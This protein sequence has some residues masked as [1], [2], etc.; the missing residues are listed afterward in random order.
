MLRGEDPHGLLTGALADP[1]VRPVLT[2]RGD[3]GRAPRALV[4][5]RL[6]PAAGA[7]VP[8]L[9]ALVELL[10]E[11][12]CDEITIGSSLSREDRDRG[13]VSV[14]QRAHSS[15]LTGR[16]ARG[17]PYE[18]VDLRRETVPAPVPTTSVLSGHLVS[19]RWLAADLR[20]VVAGAATDLGEGFTGCLA[21]LAAAAA[22]VPGAAPCDVVADLLTHLPPHLGVVDAMATSHGPDGGRIPHEAETGV[23]LVGDPV[24]ADCVLAGLLGTDRSVSSHVRAALARTGEP[25]GAVAGDLTPLAGLRRPDPLVTAAARVV[26]ADPSLGRLL[27]AAVG[28][29]DPG[30][31]PTDPGAHPT[32]PVLATLRRVLTPLVEGANEPVGR[33][34]LLQ[35]LGVA[36]LVS[37]QLRGWRTVLDKDRV[38]RV[39]VPL[40]FAPADYAGEEY[41]GL[42]GVLEPLLRP[43]RD[44][45]VGAGGFRWCLV[46]GA[47]VFETART[48][49]A[50]FAEFVARVDVAEGISLMADYLGG[51]RVVVG[52]AP[53]GGS[54]QA[55]RNLYLPQPN[56]LA[57]W[58]GRPIDVCK[59][60]LVE[61]TATEHRLW[62]RTV[63]SP[64]G[65][66]TCDD[67][68][69]TVADAGPGRTRMSVAGRQQFTLP[70]VWEVLDLGT[71][72][73]VRDLLLEEAYRVFFTATFDN[74]EARFEGRDFRIGRDPAGGDA[75]LPTAAVQQLLDVARA[76][77]ASVAPPARPDRAR[78]PDRDRRPVE[79]DVAGFAHFKGDS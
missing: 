65:S 14:P 49:R 38:D 77:A 21:A 40:G 62:W 30:T 28:G 37:T 75:P 76:W 22:E 12:G 63:A 26:L 34:A 44:L 57:L 25:S 27:R 5:T 15:G 1:L 16:T 7:S 32:D 71:L 35:L 50:D 31:G 56:Y 64:N 74:L 47:T 23:L 19:A 39:E 79:V 69:L 73:E 72:P 13:H 6:G 42:P 10:L 2:G 51:R 29:P 53:D 45:P 20:I 59:I 11:Y 9:D 61:R 36:G 58:A 78:R 8:V 48:V 60:E 41:D 17:A 3:L 52:T 46:D 55:E 24:L 33:L 18:V 67:G 66:A 4:L 54:R 68:V 70:A 43:V